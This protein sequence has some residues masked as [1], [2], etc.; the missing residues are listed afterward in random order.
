MKPTRRLTDIKFEHEGAA[1]ALVSKDQGGAANGRTT[2]IYKATDH[3]TPEQVDKAAQVTVSLEFPE[4]LRKFFGMYWEDAEVLSMTLGY[5]NTTEFDWEDKTYKDYLDSKVKSI[6]ILK[7]V[8]KAADLQKALSE[9]TPEQTVALLEDQELLE[10]AMSSALPEGE[11]LKDKPDGEPTLDT[12]LKSAHEEFVA[13]A[14][15]EAVNIEKAKF[16]EQAVVL[17]AAQD[18]LEA[19]EVAAK[20]VVEKARK[21]QLAAVQPADKVE[22]LYKA[23]APLDDESFAVAV[24]GMAVSKALEENSDLFKET[25]ATGAGEQ[26]QEEVDRT[27]EILKA[28]YANKSEIK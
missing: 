9:L 12:I 22:A 23:L 18:K 7:S 14:V 24:A 20:A 10:K 27:Q 3:I 25:G 13:K 26:D 4:F 15:S 16:D 21:E 2:L 28:K 6:S 19:L 8:Y 1:V 5:G 11:S 17:K